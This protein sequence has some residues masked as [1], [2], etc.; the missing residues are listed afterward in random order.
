MA[1]LSAR[2]VRFLENV[3][4]G[5]RNAIFSPE[6]VPKHPWFPYSTKMVDF[7]INERSEKF[8]PA[9]SNFLYH[10]M[11][12]HRK[13]SR[14]KFLVEKIFFQKMDF[15]GQPIKICVTDYSR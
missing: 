3:N 11:K 14:K 4:T 13:L 1:L 5:T 10:R 9:K 15:L 7:E 12:E 6:R 2:H 8:D